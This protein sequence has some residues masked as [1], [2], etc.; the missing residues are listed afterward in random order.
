MTC[1][2]VL[3]AVKV[4]TVPTIASIGGSS[5][6]IQSSQSG[7]PLQTVTIVQQAPM[8]Q[9]QLPIKAITQNGTHSITTAIQGSASSGE[10]HRS[11]VERR[12]GEL[13][14]NA[15]M[16]KPQLS[17]SKILL[18]VFCFINIFKYLMAQTAQCYLLNEP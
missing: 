10:K 11:S 9:H 14:G 17:V 8:G 13:Y 12:C 16:E 7:T 18:E 2:C 15:I 4:E 5:R 1:L 6:I 3:I